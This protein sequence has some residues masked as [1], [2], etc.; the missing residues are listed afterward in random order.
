LR[1][2]GKLYFTD[3]GT[4]CALVGIREP[5]HLANHPLRGP[6]FENLVVGE[7]LKA[8]TNRARRPSLFFWRDHTGNEVDLLAGDDTNLTGVEIKS[9]STVASDWA[10]G[11][12]F[13]QK[14][15]GTALAHA[16]IL[17]GGGNSLPCGIARAVPL[18][19]ACGKEFFCQPVNGCPAGPSVR[20][21]MSMRLP[22]STF[23]IHSN[24]RLPCMSPQYLASLKRDDW[25]ENAQ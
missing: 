18:D 24:D 17:H 6:I 16:E 7:Y 2:Y 13:L 14:V 20:H 9:G 11:L 19:P 8:M 21:A 23:L 3:T 22:P 4:V 12:A 5:G 10:R 15:S 25:S 1:F